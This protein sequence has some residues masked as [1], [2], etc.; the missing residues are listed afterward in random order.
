MK[1]STC[2]KC[3]GQIPLIEEGTGQWAEV[4]CAACQWKA[5]KK[6]N[7]IEKLRACIH[8]LDILAEAF[9]VYFGSNQT[10][11]GRETETISTSYK[12]RLDVLN[13]EKK[14]ISDD[15]GSDRTL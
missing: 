3:G 12:Q 6:K 9:R 1:Y 15:S 8:H 5:S 14:G 11:L 7:L 10:G 4:D 2:P 13:D